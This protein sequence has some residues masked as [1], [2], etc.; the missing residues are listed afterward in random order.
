[1]FAFVYV[2]VWRNLMSC[3]LFRE[4]GS[5]GRKGGSGRLSIR[6]SETVEELRK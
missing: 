1:V 4:A 6:I 2:N 3:Q 5:V